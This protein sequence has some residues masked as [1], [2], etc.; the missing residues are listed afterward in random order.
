MRQCPITARSSAAFGD[1]EFG[2]APASTDGEPYAR[3]ACGPIK[4]T[5]RNIRTC[6]TCAA[7]LHQMSGYYGV[8]P[9]RACQIGV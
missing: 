6:R 4:I 3:K 8:G 5:R 1:R 2:S 9:H 7:A